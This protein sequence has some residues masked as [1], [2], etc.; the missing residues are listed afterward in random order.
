MKWIATFFTPIMVLLII[1]TACNT[2]DFNANNLLF[3]F[4][5]ESANRQKI[6]S[7]NHILYNSYPYQVDSM[8]NSIDTLTLSTNEKGHYYLTKSLTYSKSGEISKS[9]ACLDKATSLM[10]N[11]ISEKEN[12]NIKLIWA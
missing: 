12:A 1:S 10:P 9:I 5:T 11:S 8:L 4:R 6:D 3:F 7:I 2:T